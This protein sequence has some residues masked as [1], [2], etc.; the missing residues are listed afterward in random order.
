[1]CRIH[2]SAADSESLVL[3]E[4]KNN[5]FIKIGGTKKIHD[6]NS[7]IFFFKQK[8]HSK[9]GVFFGKLALYPFRKVIYVPKNN[10]KLQSYSR[11][12]ILTLPIFNKFQL[13]SQIWQWDSKNFVMKFKSYN[14]QLIKFPK[15][16]LAS[17]SIHKN[18]SN[19]QFYVEKRV[20]SNIKAVWN[21]VD[22]TR[23]SVFSWRY[24]QFP[25]FDFDARKR[26]WNFISWRLYDL[27]FI[28][29]FLEF[30]CQ[31]W[32]QSWNLLKI[33]RVKMDFYWITLK[34]QVICWDIY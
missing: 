2:E 28:T 26:F 13:W 25:W 17:K 21:S 4:Y 29:K 16:F 34:F 20:K 30:H 1:M 9:F 7:R 5:I 27:N 33:G 10:L 15:R 32:L 22:F 3:T 31:I 18:W 19:L 8:I 12:F 23:F 14:L 11:N 6:P 24:L